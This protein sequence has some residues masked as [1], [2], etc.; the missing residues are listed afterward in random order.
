MKRC[1]TKN[2]QATLPLACGPIWRSLAASA[3][4]LLF[5]GI[6]PAASAS[7]MTF[8]FNTLGAGASNTS[9]QQAMQAVVNSAHPGGTVSVTGATTQTSYNGDGYVTG[10]V[11]STSTGRKVSSET[12]GTSDLGMHHSGYDAFVVNSAHTGSDRVTMTFSF[13]IY[14]VSFDYEIFPD[15]TG[16]L[17]DF[18][19]LAGATAASMNL[20]FHTDGVNPSAS[21]C[22][23][24]P[25]SGAVNCET[26]PQYLGS[27]GQLYFPNGVQALTFQDWPVMI[28]IDNLTIQDAPEPGTLALLGLGIATLAGRGRKRSQ[29]C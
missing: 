5:L 3:S 1:D 29:L 10:P 12:L 4:S 25:K 15:G 28:G 18:T 6:T 26:H 14:A 11:V 27:S 2:P 20:I 19:F 7:V 21:T 16:K 23:H 22:A 17:P 8:D 24:S 13:P 9:V